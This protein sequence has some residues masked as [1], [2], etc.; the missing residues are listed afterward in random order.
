MSEMLLKTADTT[1]MR[2]FDGISIGGRLLEEGSATLVKGC[3][4]GK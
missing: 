4:D 1:P 3:F 2:E